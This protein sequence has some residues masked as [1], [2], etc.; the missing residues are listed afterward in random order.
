[1]PG[2]SSEGYDQ[3]SRITEAVSQSVSPFPIAEAISERDSN[4]F[5]FNTQKAI[6]SKSLL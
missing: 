3:L 4:T 1:M 2:Y 5:E 6:Q